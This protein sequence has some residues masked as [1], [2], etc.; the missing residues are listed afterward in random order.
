MAGTCCC[1]ACVDC[2]KR[3]FYTLNPLLSSLDSMWECQ[4]MVVLLFAAVVSLGAQT[5]HVIKFNA[6]LKAQLVKLFISCSQE[7]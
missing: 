7:H 1:Y 5:H 2:R 3:R 4:L 6:I